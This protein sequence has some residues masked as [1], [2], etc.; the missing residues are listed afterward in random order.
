MQ[1]SPDQ[2]FGTHKV[3]RGGSRGEQT[4]RAKRMH[5]VPGS[6]QVSTAH[7][8]WKCMCRLKRKKWVEEGEDTW[9]FF[10]VSIT[11]HTDSVRVSRDGTTLHALPAILRGHLVRH[12]RE[13]RTKSNGTQKN[14]VP[15]TKVETT[16]EYPCV[17]SLPTPPQQKKK[18]IFPLLICNSQCTLP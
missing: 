6:R 14:K 4:K 17:C 16:G 7:R 8:D 1:R 3:I 13:E 18:Y 12:R 5:T 11:G 10:I 2:R 15:R 9:D